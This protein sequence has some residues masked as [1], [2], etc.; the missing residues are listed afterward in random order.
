MAKVEDKGSVKNEP[1]VMN[2]HVSR[3]AELLVGRK[4]L[5][6]AIFRAYTTHCF[7]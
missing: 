2:A 5:L 4:S 1:P 3:A 7:A 6:I